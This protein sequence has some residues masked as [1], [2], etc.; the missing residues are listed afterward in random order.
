[1][2]YKFFKLIIV[3]NRYCIKMTKNKKKIQKSKLQIL[4]LH[5]LSLSFSPNMNIMIR[6]TIK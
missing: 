6:T 5:S 1:M 3:R 2:K 4:S